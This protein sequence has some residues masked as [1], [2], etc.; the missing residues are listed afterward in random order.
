M[1]LSHSKIP[2]YVACLLCSLLAVFSL[3][4]LAPLTLSVA[5]VQL[6]ENVWHLLGLMIIMPLC[7]GTGKKEKS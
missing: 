2:I 1:S 5:F 7:F 4:T 6:M 3:K